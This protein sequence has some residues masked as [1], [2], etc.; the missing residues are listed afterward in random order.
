MREHTHRIFTSGLSFSVPILCHPCI[1]SILFCAYL[2]YVG[3]YTLIL[4]LLSIIH[5]SPAS[6]F[7][8]FDFSLRMPHK[9]QD[10]QYY[11]CYCNVE[12]SVTAHSSPAT[13]IFRIRETVTENYFNIHGRVLLE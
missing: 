11:Y 9:N 7:Q 6:S 10:M 2:S 3:I 4:F 13:L 12:V 8:K 5:V 1:N